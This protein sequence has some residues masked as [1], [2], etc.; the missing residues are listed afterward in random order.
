VTDQGVVVLGIPIPS[1][2]KL[3]LGI[4]ALH[5][6]A[7]L[8]CVAAGAVAM[9]SPKRSGRHP[10]AG[11]AYY[12]SLVVVFLSMT[13][14]AL[15]RWPADTHLLILGILSFVAGAIGRTARRQRWSHWLRIH[16]TGMGV[17]YV[18]LLTAFYVDNGP[19][20]PLWRSIPPLAHWIAPGL[21]GLPILVWA[22]VRHPLV[23]GSR[24]PHPPMGTA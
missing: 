12:W 10:A 14:L 23:R 21:V 24:P 22:F 13:A 8:T 9:L 3:F 2:S 11:T 17:S 4:V 5:V 7:G 18:L 20:L 16:L 19:H 6:V 15:M 1:S